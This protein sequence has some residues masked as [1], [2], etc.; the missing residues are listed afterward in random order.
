[1]DTENWKTLVDDQNWDAL[2]AL[3]FNWHTCPDEFE[4][5]D[6]RV[7]RMMGP[8]DV[9]WAFQQA[10]VRNLQDITRVLTRQTQEVVWVF[11]QAVDTRDGVA[12]RQWCDQYNAANSGCEAGLWVVEHGR[13]DALWY[14]L[15]ESTPEILVMMLGKS[16]R[17]SDTTIMEILLKNCAYSPVD[18][19]DVALE[20][21]RMDNVKGL[22]TL[23]TY[24]DPKFNNSWLLQMLAIHNPHSACFDLVYQKSDPVVARDRI[25]QR[26]GK[27]LREHGFQVLSAR[28]EKEALIDA[29]GPSSSAVPSTRKI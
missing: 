15:S 4:H 8:K 25:S 28:I 23:L 2:S 3:L 29:L 26:V 22:Q 17:F 24:Y 7:L 6:W 20:L 10:C 12:L 16:L 13:T 27:N 14:F 11:D 5:H 18:L 9:A 21:G 19:A 1:M